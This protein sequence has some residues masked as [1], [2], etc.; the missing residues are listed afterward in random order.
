MA[1]NIFGLITISLNESKFLPSMFQPRASWLNHWQVP[2]KKNVELET[3]WTQWSELIAFYLP[4]CPKVDPL[5]S[6]ETTEVL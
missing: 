6:L 1:V 2:C 4:T 5:A 3:E